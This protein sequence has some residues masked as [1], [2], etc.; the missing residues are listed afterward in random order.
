MVRDEEHAAARDARVARV[1]ASGQGQSEGPPAGITSAAA[2]SVT[3]AAAI[4]TTPP[5]TPPR[6]PQP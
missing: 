5:A 3:R 6:V 2:F 1:G 4:T